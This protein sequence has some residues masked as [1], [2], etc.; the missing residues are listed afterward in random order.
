MQIL[1]PFPYYKHEILGILFQGSPYTSGEI[2]AK[3]IKLM[4]DTHPSRA[5]V[6]N[7]LQTLVKYDHVTFQ[8]KTG[9]GGIHRV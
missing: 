2:H 6:I 4:E 8:E 1:K 9:K 7:F 5:S 3:L